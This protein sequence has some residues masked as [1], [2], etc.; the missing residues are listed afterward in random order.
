MNE[1]E[2]INTFDQRGEL[3][4]LVLEVKSKLANDRVLMFFVQ[5]SVMSMPLGQTNKELGLLLF[6]CHIKLWISLRFNNMLVG[7]RI[8]LFVGD[9]VF[10]STITVSIRICP[11]FPL[12]CDLRQGVVVY[13]NDQNT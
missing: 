7:A 13:I 5:L 11:E 12:V 8:E 6:L 4:L 9:L 1:D 3:V 10:K 2:V